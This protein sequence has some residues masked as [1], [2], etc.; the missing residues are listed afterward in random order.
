MRCCAKQ[1][2]MKVIDD[3]T[4]LPE[5]LA[6]KEIILMYCLTISLVSLQWW[7]THVILMYDMTQLPMSTIQLFLVFQEGNK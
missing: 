3:I 1:S 7:L 2:M 6:N 4:V 5:Y